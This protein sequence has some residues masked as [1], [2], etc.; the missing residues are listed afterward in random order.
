MLVTSSRTFFSKNGCTDRQEERCGIFGADSIQADGLII[1]N[2]DA[3]V[4]LRVDERVHDGAINFAEKAA[5][6]VGLF[7][8]DHV[9]VVVQH[10]TIQV[11]RAA[12]SFT[13]SASA[14]FQK[15]SHV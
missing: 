11:I 7:G 5:C 14:L 3:L 6:L 1:V 13:H 9:A 4:H 2:S 8:D 10:V 15:Y 12:C